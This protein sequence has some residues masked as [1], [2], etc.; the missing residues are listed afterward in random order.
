MIV[1]KYLNTDL[2]VASWDAKKKRYCIKYRGQVMYLHRAVYIACYGDLK[3]NRELHHVDGNKLNNHINNLVA[4]TPDVHKMLHHGK[5]E[6]GYSEV[7]IV[8]NTKSQ[9][10]KDPPMILTWNGE[11]LDN[12]SKYDELAFEL[13]Y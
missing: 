4:V 2:G 12:L 8:E 7:E 3:F 11:T 10:R 6:H 9:A 1:K 13:G 5:Y